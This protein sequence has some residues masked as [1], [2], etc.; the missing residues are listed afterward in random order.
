MIPILSGNVAT[1]LGGAYEVANSCR[2]NSADSAYMSRT[3]SSASNQKTWT[4]SCWVKKCNNGST[5]TLITNR[6]DTNNRGYINWYNDGLYIVAVVG[7]TDVLLATTTEKYR[8]NSAWYHVCVVQDTTESTGSDR[9]KCF[10][11]NV[12]QTLTF[13]ATPSEDADLCIN[14]DGV[15]RIGTENAGG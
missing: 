7:G 10:V 11:N 12:R 2:F 9:V 14:D 1:A 4:F 5:Q 8:D 3:P 13:S 6:T 15:H